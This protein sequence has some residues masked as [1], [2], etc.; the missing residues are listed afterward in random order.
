M[1]D[2]ETTFQSI[3]H[4]TGWKQV[5]GTEPGQ[6]VHSLWKSALLILI[7]TGLFVVYLLVKPGPPQA[8]TLVDNLTQ[9]LLEG[10]GLFLALP[11]WLIWNRRKGPSDDS[12]LP[13]TAVTNPSQRWVPF[14]LSLVF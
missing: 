12:L 11:L 6:P 9:G 10:V 7:L 8:V 2:T 5:T 3:P 14:L 4:T 13:N 1:A